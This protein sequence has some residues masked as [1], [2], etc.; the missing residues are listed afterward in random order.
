MCHQDRKAPGP[1]RLLKTGYLE[2][3]RLESSADDIHAAIVSPAV[4]MTAEVDFSDP[5]R[6]PSGSKSAPCPS[7][8]N[9][10][11]SRILYSPS[12][13]PVLCFSRS[14]RGS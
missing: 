5:L 14:A 11:P 6:E 4:V 2:F 3:A 8:S 12:L 1:R 7:T 9:Y 10:Q 13:S